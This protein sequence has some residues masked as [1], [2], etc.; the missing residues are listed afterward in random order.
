MPNR[1]LLASVTLAVVALTS[2]YSF[3]QGASQDAPP[4]LGKP[5]YCYTKKWYPLRPALHGISGTTTLDFTVMTDGFVRDVRVART[6]GSSEL[7]EAAAKCVEAGWHYIPA[8]LNGV[9]V[10]TSWTATIEFV[11][12]KRAAAITIVNDKAPSAPQ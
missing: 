10:E 7:D 1:K 2:Q 11:S 5:H 8:K 12:N 3:A 9:A 4:P 6:S